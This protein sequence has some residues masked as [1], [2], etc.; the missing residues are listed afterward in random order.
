MEKLIHVLCLNF[1][2]FFVNGVLDTW[3]WVIFFTFNF[4]SRS[5]KN[6][7]FWKIDPDNLIWFVLF[8]CTSQGDDGCGSGFFFTFVCTKSNLGACVEIFFGIYAEEFSSVFRCSLFLPNP[9]EPMC[10]INC[11]ARNCTL[12]PDTMARLRIVYKVISKQV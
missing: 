4:F 11:L 7:F 3:V 12:S 5:P 6:I 2:L 1:I 9:F 10:I 8:C